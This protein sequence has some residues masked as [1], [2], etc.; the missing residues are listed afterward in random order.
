MAT[1]TGKH[2]LVTGATGGLGSRVCRELIAAGAVISLAGRDETKLNAISPSSARYTVDLALPG[3]A[4]ALVDAA[5]AASPIDGVIALHGVVAFG[6]AVE[7]PG[8]V[9]RTLTAVNLSS[10]I[11][12]ISS[13]TPQLARAAEAGREPFIMTVSGIIAD[14]PTTGMAA[15]GASKAGL[16]SFVQAASREL[17]RQGV[18][19]VDARP[20][21]TNTDLSAHPIFG[22]APAMAQGFD[23]DAVARRLVEAIVNDEKDVPSDAFA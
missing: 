22:K 4:Q 23:P 12:L 6:P 16:K 17:R 15:Y 1:L 8:E 18:R 14:M 11:E 2:I 13:V 21:H 7:M 10:V 9:S 3:A 20:G 5:S 19:L